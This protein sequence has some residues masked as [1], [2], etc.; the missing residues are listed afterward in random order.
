MKKIVIILLVFVLTACTWSKESKP[1]PFTG[2]M[3]KF[4]AQYSPVHASEDLE[5]FNQYLDQI[6]HEIAENYDLASYLFVFENPEKYNIKKPTTVLEHFDYDADSKEDLDFYNQ[7]LEKLKEFNFEELSKVQQAYYRNLEYAFT[8]EIDKLQFV[9]YMEAFEPF[10]GAQTL[11]YYFISFKLDTADKV[12]DYIR[13]FEAFPDYAQSALDFSNKQLNHGLFMNQLKAEDALSE[14]ESIIQNSKKDFTQAF[15]RKLETAPVDNPEELLQRFTLAVEKNIQ[16][17]QE[18][19]TFLQD[20]IQSGKLSQEGYSSYKKGKEYF[21]TLVNENLGYHGSVEE[22]IDLMKDAL[23]I[24]IK[25]IQDLYPKI[26]EEGITPDQLAFT[27]IEIIDR[28]KDYYT[29]KFPSIGNFNYVVEV[30]E[31]KGRENRAHYIPRKIGSDFGGTI[32]IPEDSLPSFHNFTTMI[33]EAIPG[34]LYQYNFFENLE[35]HP[36]SRVFSYRGYSEGWAMY[37]E[38]YGLEFFPELNQDDLLFQL[39]MIK[40]DVVVSTLIALEVNNGASYKQIQR[41]YGTL[42]QNEE[43]LELL[44]KRAI[45]DP[46]DDLAYG[47]G[48]VM[49]DNAFDYANEQLKDKF[50]FIEFHR[51]LLENGNQPFVYVL[52]D[53]QD[54]VDQHK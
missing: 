9:N 14:V 40:V 49:F 35:R 32:R 3:A 27:P 50:D 44:Y 43:I 46:L 20:A 5:A 17:Y 30:I 37:I 8:Q 47:A 28:S 26:S 54:Y 41:D 2:G 23:S 19:K 45:S 12:E 22:V 48:W 13:I 33:H 24:T 53:V 6:F 51:S 15:Q 10:N 29:N 25:Q 38:R 39:L 1:T 42:I 18:I 4:Q 31:E 36:I 11:L 16:S 34:H 7:Q 21:R 52:L